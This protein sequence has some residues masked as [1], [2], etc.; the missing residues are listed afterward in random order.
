MATSNFFTSYDLI[1]TFIS[2]NDISISDFR[3]IRQLNSTFFQ[4]CNLQQHQR[5]NAAKIIQYYWRKYKT[6]S[7]KYISMQDGKF[8]R[9]KP[10]LCI[11][12]EY[13]LASTRT[14]ISYREIVKDFNFYKL[15][16]KHIKKL[17]SYK[18]QR[19]VL[20]EMKLS[21]DIRNFS[22]NDTLMLHFLNIEYRRKRYKNKFCS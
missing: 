14:K 9:F 20:K 1:S 3:T 21:K 13:L 8:L 6:C 4:V 16:S 5:K 7:K 22:N 19:L 15:R 12:N 18:L 11:M 2:N 10:H 17:L